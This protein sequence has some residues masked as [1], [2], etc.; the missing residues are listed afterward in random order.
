VICTDAAVD[1]IAP[2]EHCGSMSFCG[3]VERYPDT[4][5]MGY[6]FSRPFVGP[7]ASAIRSAIVGLPSAAARTVSIRHTA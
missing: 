6:P 1:R 4:R 5:D 2:A 3:A 7:K